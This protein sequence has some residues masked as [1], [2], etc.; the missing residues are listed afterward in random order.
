MREQ[1]G[2]KNGQCEG[3]YGWLERFRVETHKGAS[4]GME[5][6]GGECKR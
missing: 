4:R 1:G 3:G 5:G 2:G 6:E